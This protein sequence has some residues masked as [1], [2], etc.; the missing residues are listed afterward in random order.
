MSFNV[1]I[2]STSISAIVV[3]FVSIDTTYVRQL[4]LNYMVRAPLNIV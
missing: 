2:T 4:Y 1:T 3:Q